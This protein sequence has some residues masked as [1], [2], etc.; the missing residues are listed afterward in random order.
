MFYYLMTTVNNVESFWQKGGRSPLS[1][2]SQ[3]MDFTDEPFDRPV[4]KSEH[5]SAAWSELSVKIDLRLAL[6]R[7]YLIAFQ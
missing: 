6:T 1:F 4:A 2:W 7:M 3:S 5:V